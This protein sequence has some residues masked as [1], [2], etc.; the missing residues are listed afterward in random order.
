MRTATAFS[1][2]ISSGELRLF[3]RA[4][5]KGLEHLRHL[6]CYML[7]G[8]HSCDWQDATVTACTLDMR[9][10]HKLT[11]QINYYTVWRLAQKHRADLSCLKMRLPNVAAAQCATLILQTALS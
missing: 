2:P 1:S 8:S 9:A 5:G 10:Q 7:S 4:S 3:A 11:A 6:H